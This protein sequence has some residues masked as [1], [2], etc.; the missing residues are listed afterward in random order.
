MKTQTEENHGLQQAK[1]QFESIKEMVENYRKAQES[2]D[3]NAQ[4]ETRE[5]I[6]ED[7]LSVQVRSTWHTPGAEA[8][9]G[10]EFEILL[11]WGGP[12]CRIIGELNEYNEPENAN[13]QYQDWG[14]PWTDHLLDSSEEDDIL[15][16]YCRVFY[17]GE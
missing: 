9:K 2:D 6:E 10:G 17:F 3:D 7:A 11:C 4:D 5:R 16:D 8:E 14:T 13:L 12:A 1:A 15:L